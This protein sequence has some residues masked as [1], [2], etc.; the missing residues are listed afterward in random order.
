MQFQANF[1]TFFTYIEK[2]VIKFTWNCKEPQNSQ[3]KVEKRQIRGLTLLMC[4]QYVKNSY[5]KKTKITAFF[6]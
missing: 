4:P 2:L 5:I 6:K 1:N 3:S